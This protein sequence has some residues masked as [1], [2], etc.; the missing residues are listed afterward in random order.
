MG[1][2]PSVDLGNHDFIWNYAGITPM[3][4]PARSLSWMLPQSVGHGPEVR[5][6]EAVAE[7]VYGVTAGLAFV[8]C[9]K[10]ADFS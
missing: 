10:A 4:W 7:N 2:Q 1:I 3:T 8:L 5:F 9:E 6:R